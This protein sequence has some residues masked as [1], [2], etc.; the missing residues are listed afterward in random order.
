[1][2]EVVVVKSC[3]VKH[4][5]DVPAG[6]LRACTAV[7]EEGRSQRP[8]ARDFGLARTTVRKMF[9]YSIPP[10]YHRKEPAKRPKVGMWVGVIDVILEEDK[11]KPAKQGH[12]AQ[13]IFKR[14]RAE[15]PFHGGYTI[16]K[17]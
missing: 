10:G 16:V 4:R 13:R 14:L 5:R 12:T 11:T 17:D 1:M 15:H 6:G 8:V 7:L 9:G 2:H 3:C